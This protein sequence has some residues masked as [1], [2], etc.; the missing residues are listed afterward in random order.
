[1]RQWHH[2]PAGGRNQSS[3]HP[4]SRWKR[5]EPPSLP[6]VLPPPPHLVQHLVPS[7]GEPSL[8]EM[9]AGPPPPLLPLLMP[10]PLSRMLYRWLKMHCG[11]PPMTCCKP[12]Y[13]MGW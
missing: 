3:L 7:K 6:T 1:M 8:A 4:S 9:L 11:E 12:P 5:Q 2:K 10:I 13:Q